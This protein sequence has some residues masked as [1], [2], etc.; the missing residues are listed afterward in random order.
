MKK[1]VSV[2]S[3]VVCLLLFCDGVHAQTGNVKPIPL[4]ISD[5]MTS[6]II[7]PTDILSADRGSQD[8]LV[9][10]AAGS[11]NILQVKA[12]VAV[13]EPSN[14]SVITKGGRFF[15]FIVS[16]AKTP[17]DLNITIPDSVA[18]GQVIL[19]DY[20]VPQDFSRNPFPFLNKKRKALN[21]RF[22]LKSIY[23]Y[24][25][26]LLFGLKIQNYSMLEYPVEAIRFYIHD[27]KKAKRTAIQNVELENV[28]TTLCPVVKG[29][30]SVDVVVGVRSFTIP[31]YK[32]LIIELQEKNG[33]RNI[34]LRIKSK[35]LLK[36]RPY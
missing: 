11:D 13:F 35:T 20:P 4:T 1:I 32:D 28:F 21:T 9:Q 8:I 17:V 31:K 14:I 36:A 15:S 5:R 27:R 23:L 30:Q 34:S 25:G 6:N 33:S 29:K 24:N 7:F 26:V 12:A 2:I 10:K 3:G 22:A 19:S 18:S 16:Y